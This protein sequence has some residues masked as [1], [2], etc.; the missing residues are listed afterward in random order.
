MAQKILAAPPP[1]MFVGPD[2]PDPHAP[3]GGRDNLFDK[4]LI[5]TDLVELLYKYKLLH[6]QY[7]IDERTSC[8]YKTKENLT[9]QIVDAVRMYGVGPDNWKALLKYV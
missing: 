4:M 8:W 1:Y 7:E 6:Q 2:G 5:D 9:K 3:W